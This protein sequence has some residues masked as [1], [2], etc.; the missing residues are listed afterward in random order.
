MCVCVC[1][2]VKERERWGGGGGREDDPGR[3]GNSG[4][5]TEKEE[6]LQP[7]VHQR[8]RAIF[9]RHHPHSAHFSL[10][11]TIGTRWR[12]KRERREKEERK[13]EN[14]IITI[15]IRG[16]EGEIPFNLHE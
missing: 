11:I 16:G 4:K 12:K 15:E 3:L 7:V 2:C 1:V 14:E 13:R 5:S 8:S 10:S 9:S 6:E